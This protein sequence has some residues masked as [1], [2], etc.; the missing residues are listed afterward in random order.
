[1]PSSAP[2]KSDNELGSLAAILAAPQECL[3]SATRL[4][5][6]LRAAARIGAATTGPSACLAAI[7][8]M[9][10]PAVCDRIRSA[11]SIDDPALAA[12]LNL[13]PQMV[14][15][16]RR[17]E[18]DESLRQLGEAVHAAAL[19]LLK[20]AKPRS[21]L[22][23]ALLQCSQSMSPLRPP[24]AVG[25]HCA[26]LSRGRSRSVDVRA[27]RRAGIWQGQSLDAV[28]MRRDPLGSILRSS[29]SSRRTG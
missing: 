20:A 9:L 4:L 16:L 14:S 22:A 6:V 1:L 27:S 19:R 3:G 2:R 29:V 13:G 21:D 5:E 15:D 8:R 23:L 12:A 26:A 25:Q 17:P 7:G 11:A 10:L 18:V 28:A 24:R